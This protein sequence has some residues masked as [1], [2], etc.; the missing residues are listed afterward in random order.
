M[1]VTPVNRR[2]KNTGPATDGVGLIGYCARPGCRKEFRREVIAGRPKRFCSD[3]CQQKARTERRSAEAKVRHAEDLLRQARIDLVAF[4]ADDPGAT[5]GGTQ[6]ARL[7]VALG[8]ARTA[9]RYVDKDAAGIHEL[10][11][12][13]DAVV[14]ALAV[15]TSTS[16]A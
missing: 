5:R 8:Q 14:A 12:L 11:E 7:Q 16:V 6:D 13:T 15:M 2:S 3:P 10:Q 1:T 4:D 9:L